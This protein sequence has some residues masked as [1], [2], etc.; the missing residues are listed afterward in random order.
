M[1]QYSGKHSLLVYEWKSN[2]IESQLTHDWNIK[3]AGMKTETYD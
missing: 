1:C 3:I 2:M